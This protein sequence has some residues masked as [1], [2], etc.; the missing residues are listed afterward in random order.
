MNEQTKV[1][2]D[3]INGLIDQISKSDDEP[4]QEV[5][6]VIEDL[7]TDIQ[8]LKEKKQVD[9]SKELLTKLDTLTQAVTDGGKLSTDT[10]NSIVEAIQKIKMEAPIVNVTPP[11]V[12]VTVPEI[13]VPSVNIPEQKIPEPK[14]YFP[15]EMS[16]KKP[17]WI[18]NLVDLTSV[19]QGLK[20]IYDVVRGWKLPTD[21]KNPVSVRLSNGEKFYNALGGMMSAISGAFPFKK[22]DSTDQ[23][24]LV[25][26]DGTQ[27]VEV[28]NISG[29]TI[30]ADQ[31]NL[32]TDQLEAKLDTLITQTAIGTPTHFSGTVGT[33]P[34]DTVTPASTTKSILIENTHATQ[35]IL[36]SLDGGSNWKTIRPYG[37]LSLDVAVTSFQVKG[38]GASTTYEGIYTT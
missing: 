33:T 28:T 10:T 24:A 11:E 8:L 20:A 23:A 38:S 2:I 15:D 30:D 1:L 32:N 9:N 5:L 7:S 3:E 37:V 13:K 36:I 12:N 17:S 25:R 34:V 26:D 4:S 31:I 22:A 18:E 21:P 35:N 29:L 6:D 14:V 19:M 27:V 16:I